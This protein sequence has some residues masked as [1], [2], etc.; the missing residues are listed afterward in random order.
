MIGFCA[1]EPFLF[2]ARPRGGELCV[3]A[4][5][6]GN[7]ELV[8][9]KPLHLAARNSAHSSWLRYIPLKCNFYC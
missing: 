7:E 4:G 9:F 6:G 5:T 3:P 1:Q 2:H 8:L